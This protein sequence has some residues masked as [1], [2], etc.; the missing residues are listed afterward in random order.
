MEKT[1]RDKVRD[2]A[3]LSKLD[4]CG[5]DLRDKLIKL[6]DTLYLSP[7][8]SCELKLGR[9][10]SY[11]YSYASSLPLPPSLMMV[12]VMSTRSNVPPAH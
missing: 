11:M 1:S 5:S 8:V 9:M 6:F 4:A 12:V 2:E 3:E 7:K 10:I